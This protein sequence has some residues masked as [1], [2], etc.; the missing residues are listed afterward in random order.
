MPSNGELSDTIKLS[1]Q[2]AKEASERVRKIV[3]LLTVASIVTFIACWNQYEKGW[4]AHRLETAQQA[5]HYLCD[6]AKIAGKTDEPDGECTYGYEKKELTKAEIVRSKGFLQEWQFTR[7]QLTRHIQDLQDQYVS[8]VLKINVPF[9]G[10]TSDINDLGI[11]SGIA[12]VTLAGL[13]LFS[14]S[15]EGQNVK[16]LFDLSREQQELP[17]VLRLF[18]MTQVFTIPP[19]NREPGATRVTGFI[20]SLPIITYSL[21]VSYD[22]W[23]TLSRPYYR[24]PID[25]LTLTFEGCAFVALAAIRFVVMRIT[26]GLDRQW[27][28][29]LATTTKVPVSDSPAEAD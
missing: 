25:W 26:R 12:L 29:A 4:T 28:E 9:F 3:V 8:G 18:A 11:L 6:E 16:Q 21:V 13:F 5:L 23:Q 19:W 15:R 27:R 1:L 22:A 2:Y 20:H 10:L 24:E 14:I 7:K 17:R